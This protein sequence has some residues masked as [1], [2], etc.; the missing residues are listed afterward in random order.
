MSGTTATSSN[1]SHDVIHL[2]PSSPGPTLPE[3]IAV[4]ISSS[5]F[6][7]LGCALGGELSPLFLSHA[8]P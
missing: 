1:D 7:I 6:V 4:I 5:F 8:E 2:E 3:A